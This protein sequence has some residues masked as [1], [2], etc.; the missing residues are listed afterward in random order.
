MG[1][2]LD[3]H[4]VQ[5]QY[6]QAWG[7]VSTVSPRLWDLLEAVGDGEAPA[8]V[9]HVEALERDDKDADARVLACHLKE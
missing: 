9:R 2:W 3:G 6:V 5:Q 4:Y 7:Y 8:P 1:C